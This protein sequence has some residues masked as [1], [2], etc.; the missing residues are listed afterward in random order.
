MRKLKV[1]VLA[2][3]LLTGTAQADDPYPRA[4]WYADL[5]TI[6]Y[7]VSG[8]VTIIDEHTLRVD[9]FT[10]TGGGIADPGVFFYLGAS[11]SFADLAAGVGVGPNLH[12]QNWVD[13]TFETIDVP[14]GLDGHNAI[15]VWCVGAGANFGSGTFVVPEPTALLLALPVSCALLPRRPRAH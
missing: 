9:D 14:G 12:G 2:A 1:T 7:E 8:R 4:G 11:E 3:F 5:S 15:S 10:Y 13:H 6:A